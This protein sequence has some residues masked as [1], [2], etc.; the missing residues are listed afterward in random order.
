MEDANIINRI[1]AIEVEQVPDIDTL[2]SD[3]IET[4]NSDELYE[5]AE[6]PGYL[7][8][9]HG[10]ALT[11]DEIYPITA[12]EESKI[13]AFIGP[14]ESGK[15]TIETTIYQLFQRTPFCGLY[16]SDSATLTGYEERSFY[17]R[18]NSKN[19][20]ASTLRTSRFNE[21]IFLHMKLFDP[22]TNSKTNYLF[23]DISGE[24]I[25]SH[26]GNVTTLKENMPFLKATDDYTFVLD[27]VQLADKTLRNGAIDSMRNM[28]RTIFDAQLF[29]NH[30]HAQIIVSKYDAIQASADANLKAA[31]E[32]SVQS[33][34]SLVSKYISD[35]T[36][37]NIAAMPQN[38][39]L[40]IGYGID[41]LL[42]TW[43]QKNCQ[44]SSY[45]PC[46]PTNNLKSEFNK[47]NYK[48]LGGET[49]G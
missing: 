39:G 36:V 16:F 35:V 34:V 33:L 24:F 29:T 10:N 46:A 7:R 31:V 20:T 15:T 37:H 48:L 3:E 45:I 30:T 28:A 11:L 23:A 17:T 8:L 41:G 5:D 22:K 44:N 49:N 38:K 1:P 40:A 9:P 43:M 32:K 18:L 21:R 13:I 42:K 12:S 27:G 6:K 25:F 19:R 4:L 14:Y 2:I 47:L 26:K